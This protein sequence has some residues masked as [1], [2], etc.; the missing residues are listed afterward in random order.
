MNTWAE[1]KEDTLKRIYSY[2]RK[3]VAIPATDGNQKD[4]LLALP[5]AAEAAQIY[6]ARYKPVVSLYSFTQSIPNV[7][8]GSFFDTVH[9]L[10][11]D[12]TYTF[13]DGKGYYFEVDNAAT[14][15]I[16]SVDGETV[17]TTITNTV[18][19]IFT[20]HRGIR[21][22][23]RIRFSGNYPYSIRHLGVFSNTYNTAPNYAPY[24]QYDIRA[25]VAEENIDRFIKFDNKMLAYQ[26]SFES[27]EAY[28]QGHPNF[29]SPDLHTVIIPYDD[30]GQFDIYYHRRPM[31]ITVDTDDAFVP[32]IWE[33]TIFL[34]PM[35]MASY[36]Y[37]NE[38]PTIAAVLYNEF[39]QALQ[40]TPFGS[41]GGY[42][43]YVSTK[44]WV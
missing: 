40:E 42:A 38:D 12:L 19:G 5:N 13:A 36:V 34:M 17:Y 32:E 35:Y 16:E 6:I 14:V 9:H 3:G 4:Y 15:Y 1:I 33:D 30:E 26:G 24:N 27:G 41:P 43:R 31:P 23:F 29:V 37:R 8:S 39:V 10:N 2:S 21:D 22:G 11:E 28:M 44:G 20:A 7:C 18:A 25:L